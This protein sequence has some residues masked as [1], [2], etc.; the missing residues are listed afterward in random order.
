MSYPRRNHGPTLDDLPEPAIEQWLVG[1][2]PAQVELIDMHQRVG[3]AVAALDRLLAGSNT[4]PALRD[5][6]LELRQLL[7]PAPRRRSGKGEVA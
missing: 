2:H 4:R 3:G 5:A 6:L 1:A 7:S